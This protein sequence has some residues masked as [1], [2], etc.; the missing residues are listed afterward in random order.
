MDEEEYID[1]LN[2]WVTQGNGQ[3]YAHKIGMVN[4]IQMYTAISAKSDFDLYDP[5]TVKMPFYDNY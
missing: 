2:K 3:L 1:E 4:G 5:R